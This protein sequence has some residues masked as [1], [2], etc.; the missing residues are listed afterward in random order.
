MNI[1][2]CVRHVCVCVR[3]CGAGLES[4][5]KSESECEYNTMFNHTEIKRN[6]TE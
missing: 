3:C 6:Y 2:V 1:N 5:V 4:A